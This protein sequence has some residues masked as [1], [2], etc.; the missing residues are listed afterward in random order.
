MDADRQK[1]MNPPTRVSLAE[2]AK[3]A[4]GDTGWRFDLRYDFFEQDQL[5]DRGSVG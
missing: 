5:R 4:G 3:V 2:L 1:Q